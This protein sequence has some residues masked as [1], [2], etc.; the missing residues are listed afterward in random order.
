[1]FF[2]RSVFLR[3]NDSNLLLCTY[4]LCS[5]ISILFTSLW[6]MHIQWNFIFCLSTSAAPDHGSQQTFLL[7][8]RH[9]QYLLK[10]SLL[11]VFQIGLQDV[12]KTSSRRLQEDVLQTRLEDVFSTSSPRRMFIGLV[13]IDTNEKLDLLTSKLSLLKYSQMLRFFVFNSTI[14]VK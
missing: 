5:D 12:F 2:G 3:F 11:D 10:T 13:P 9:L 8:L 14:Y 1:M 4:L 6:T 7:F